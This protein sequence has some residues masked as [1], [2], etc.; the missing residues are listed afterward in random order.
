MLLTYEALRPADG[1]RPRG[2][3]FNGGE[4]ISETIVAA[5]LLRGNNI[6]DVCMRV[7]ADTYPTIC[8]P[9]TRTFLDELDLECNFFF[10]LYTVTR[11]T[12]AAYTRRQ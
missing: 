10:S 1:G 7:G 8:T 9:Y 11:P 5:V 4:P 12:T 2:I 3:N 6:Y